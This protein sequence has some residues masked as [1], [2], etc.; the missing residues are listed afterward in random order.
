MAE[1]SF[2]GE[3]TDPVTVDMTEH[4][5][6]RALYFRRNTS[7]FQTERW[8]HRSGCRRWFVAV[9][10]TTTNQVERTLWAK[11]RVKGSG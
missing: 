8:Y 4:A 6:A 7:G 11:D 10:N 2:G 3:I 9:R 5:F 1:F